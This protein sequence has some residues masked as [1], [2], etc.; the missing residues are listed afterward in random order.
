MAKNA[1]YL[2]E[3]EE[4][5]KTFKTNALAQAK[6]FDL[7]NILPMYERYYDQVCKTSAWSEYV[8]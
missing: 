2:L 3:D 6:R 7:E 8:I 1:I 5:L 4:R